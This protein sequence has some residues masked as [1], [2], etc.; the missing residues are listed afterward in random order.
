[1]SE[2]KIPT[3]FGPVT[4]YARKQAA[5]NI[6][7]DAALRAKVMEIILREVSKPRLTE[8][9]NKALAEAEFARRYPESNLP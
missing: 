5:E 9:E 2:I 3:A 1:M 7:E 6:K 8:E 4:E